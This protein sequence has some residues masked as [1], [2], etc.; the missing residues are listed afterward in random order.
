LSSASCDVN[1]EN[2]SVG[3]AGEQEL[4]GER[5][6]NSSTRMFVIVSFDCVKFGDFVFG[7]RVY[8]EPAVDHASGQQTPCGVKVHVLHAIYF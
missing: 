7:T 1:S 2:A 6:P 4:T 8:E 5:K 3:G